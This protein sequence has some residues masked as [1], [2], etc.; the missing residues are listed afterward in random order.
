MSSTS[1]PD[2]TSK[3]PVT[4]ERRLELL[5]LAR[6]SRIQ[7]VLETVTEDATSAGKGVLSILTKSEDIHHN[8][9]ISASIQ[10]IFNFCTDVVGDGEFLDIE[11]MVPIICADELE[12]EGDDEA[13]PLLP[14]L[15]GSGDGDASEAVDPYAA[16]IDRLRRSGAG[17]IVK[18]LQQYV[19]KCRSTPVVT[20]LANHPSLSPSAV[21]SQISHV[22]AQCCANALWREGDS[23]SPPS[24]PVA[25]VTAEMVERFVHLKLHDL[26]LG[27]DPDDRARDETLSAR[28]QTLGFLSPEH[29]DIRSLL[30]YS[31]GGSTKHWSELLRGPMAHLEEIGSRRCPNDKMA[32]VKRWATATMS[33]LTELNSAQTAGR[34]RGRGGPPGAD[35]FLSLLILTL[36]RCNPAKLHS[37]QKYLQNYLSPSKLNSEYGYLLAQLVSA[38][39]F[40]E[41]ADAASLTISP[42]EFQLAIDASKLA[43]NNQLNKKGAQ[44]R[45]FGIDVNDPEIKS[46]TILRWSQAGDD[47]VLSPEDW[48]A[49]TATEQRSEQ[50]QCSQSLFSRYKQM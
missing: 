43:A 11:A 29:L 18:A 49:I 42:E 2:L 14:G 34:G 32:C 30:P 40:L 28:I 45:N 20:T 23:A 33:L 22:T 7:W 31:V 12:G 48:A 8:V 17:E 38:I 9:P 27:A 39:H 3:E 47:V 41:F 37:T 1:F 35:E 5:A 19:L 6:A 21:Q 44:T 16:F 15:V 36:Q 4:E 24:P 10:S 50:K 13:S 25:A 26:L 46:C